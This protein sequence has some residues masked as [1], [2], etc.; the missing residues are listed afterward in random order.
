VAEH[1]NVVIQK[2]L[3]ALEEPVLIENLPI[4][5]E[6]SIGIAL[7]P[8]HG[9]DAETLFQRA[10]VA[11]YAAKDANDAVIVR[12]TIELGHNMGIQV[13]AEGVENKEAYQRL[14]ELGCDAAQGYYMGR[15]LPAA[16]LSRWLDESPWGIEVG[17]SHEHPIQ[18]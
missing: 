1:I 18:P 5:V 17:D 6:A 11:M 2:I 7:Y 14:A 9:A 4:A 12:S 13:V 10:D 16:E 8:D 15:P 3:K